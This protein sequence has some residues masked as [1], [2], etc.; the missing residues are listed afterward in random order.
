MNEYGKRVTKKMENFMDEP[1]S[2][3]REINDIQNAIEGIEVRGALAAGVK[4]S[5][6][7]SKTAE[8]KSNEAYDITQNLLD[9]SFDTSAINQ[10]FEQRLDEEIN[11]LQP[12]W[13]Q[14]KDQTN[15][16]LADTAKHLNDV[17]INVAYPP[18][19]F[20]ALTPENSDTVLFQSLIDYCIEHK[21]KLA[22]PSGGNRYY[23]ETWQLK[24]FIEIDFKNNTLVYEETGDFLIVRTNYRNKPKLKNFT[25]IGTDGRVGNAVKVGRDDNAWGGAVDLEN[26]HIMYFN[27]AFQF[28][29]THQCEF[30]AGR[31]SYNNL[32]VE[33]HGISD[34]F[35]NTRGSFNN[36]NSFEDVQFINNTIDLKM[37]HIRQLLFM[38]C[39]FEF[40]DIMFQFYEDPSRPEE[41]FNVVEDITFDNCW[42]E[43]IGT[44]FLN[45]LKD[46]NGDPIQESTVDMSAITENN[47]YYYL[48]DRYT[49][50]YYEKRKK[51]VRRSFENTTEKDVEQPHTSYIM[52]DS[53]MYPSDISVSLST[54][55]GGVDQLVK[56]MSV[57]VFNRNIQSVESVYTKAPFEMKHKF[58]I[59][60]IFYD[61]TEKLFKI[62]IHAFSTKT[63]PKFLAEVEIDTPATDELAHGNSLSNFHLL[64][65]ARLSNPVPT[66]E[67]TSVPVGIND[68]V[69]SYGYSFTKQLSDINKTTIVTPFRPLQIECN[70]YVTS[71]N[72]SCKGVY[73]ANGVERC[74]ASDSNG[75]Y[76]G[77]DS[78][79]LIQE[80]ANKL[81]HGK[82]V[83][84]TDNGFEID[85][86]PVGDGVSKNVVVFINVAG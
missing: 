54:K 72:L 32:G 68:R 41:V 20:N 46:S 86:K 75:F 48:V 13:T 76:V 17:E 83:N 5:F 77:R 25:M 79:I 21:Y 71:T 37:S 11:N 9:E 6:D 30:K 61:E 59:G 27:K 85:W 34:D 51:T 81:V 35:P 47:C 82:V 26:F 31:I 3:D 24:D 57:T 19:P 67:D 18:A 69:Q 70:A 50:S 60:D 43:N 73:S 63:Y 64:S 16:Q 14:F 65:D 22:F 39:T 62:P 55:Y 36:M 28:Y 4:K 78:F 23:F 7:K 8:G 80:E 58:S 15:Q 1:D 74:V 2:V 45:H 29:S 44:L 56:K 49:D 84:L 66:T 12:N 38:E 52:F 42:F 40:S 53:Y 10:N 33:C